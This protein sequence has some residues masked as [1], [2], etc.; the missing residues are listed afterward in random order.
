MILIFFSSNNSRDIDS[1]GALSV[2]TTTQK[3]REVYQLEGVFRSL[4][5]SC[6]IIFI[7]RLVF[8]P[9]VP[10]KALANCQS[11]SDPSPV[12]TSLEKYALPVSLIPVKLA[13]P[14]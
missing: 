13:L 1:S 12:S 4:M 7:H 14:M 9:T 3:L 10:L 6:I 2:S 11:S 8:L 5:E